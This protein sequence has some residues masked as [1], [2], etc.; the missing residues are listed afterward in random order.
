LL[1]RGKARYDP[2]RQVHEVVALQG[3]EGWLRNPLT[4]YNYTTVRQFLRKQDFYATY[5]AGIL[6]KA[7]LRPR[8]HNL[9]LQPLREFA[10]RYW[11]LQGFRD[12][13]HGLLLSLLMA[14]YTFV[15]Y[16]RAWKLSRRA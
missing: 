16:W 10:R 8:P 4:H 11:T 7:G 3:A 13:G 15:A 5:E 6:V 2:N 9:V 1:K 14:C 12:G